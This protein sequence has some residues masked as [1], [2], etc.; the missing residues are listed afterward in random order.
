MYGSKNNDPYVMKNGKIVTKSNNSGGI[1]GGLSNGMP[2]V[3][4][5]AFK[6]ASSISKKQNTVDI[7]SK[8]AT[9]LSVTGRHDPCVVPRAPPVVDSMVSLVLADHALQ[10]GFIKPVL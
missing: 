5:V 8:K 6:P 3:L 7:K 10:G 2:I 1:L 4:R 9:I